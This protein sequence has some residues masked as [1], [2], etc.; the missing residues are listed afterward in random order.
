[1]FG[2]TLLTI[3]VAT[4]HAASL[5]RAN[6]DAQQRLVT[7]SWHLQQLLPKPHS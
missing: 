6:L 3:L 1:V 4:F 7:Q 5:S 2:A